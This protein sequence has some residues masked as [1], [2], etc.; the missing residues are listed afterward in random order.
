VSDERKK[1]RNYRIVGCV[2]GFLFPIAGA[3]G[4]AVFYANDDRE[5]AT[6]TIFASLVGAV[7]WLLLL[8]AAG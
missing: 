7:F 6:S 3:I 2:G 1:R 4:A 8:T 5:L